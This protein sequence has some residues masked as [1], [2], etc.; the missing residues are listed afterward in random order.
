MTATNETFPLQRMATSKLYVDPQHVAQAD[1]DDFAK[2]V[3]SN[4]T[5]LRV[6]RDLH[7]SSAF[8]RIENHYF[9][10]NASPFKL[11]IGLSIDITPFFKGL[12]AGRAASGETGN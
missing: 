2:C 5:V 4:S 8:A 1:K 12:H 10:N 9:I 7:F 6:Q 3:H 11:N